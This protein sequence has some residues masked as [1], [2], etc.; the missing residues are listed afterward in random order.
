MKAILFMG[1][2]VGCGDK[3]ETEAPDLVNTADDDSACGGAAPVIQAVTCENSGIIE[4]PDYGEL[5]TFSLTANV[6]DEDGDLTYYQLLVDFDENLD[7]VED[8]EDE[9]LNPVEGAVSN[10]VECET[11]EENGSVDI[12]VT[13]YLQGA[14]PKKDTRYEWFIRVAD[15]RGKTSDPFMVT[16]T[17]PDTDGNGDPDQE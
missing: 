6:T 2:L 17:T 16:C 11:P 13:I 7:G 1:L 15:A 8:E 10:G 12:G 3:E 5:P 9:Q 4:H 14:Q